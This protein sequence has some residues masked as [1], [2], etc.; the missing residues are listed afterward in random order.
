MDILFVEGWDKAIQDA[1]CDLTKA[2]RGHRYRVLLRRDAASND[3]IQRRLEQAGAICEISQ[4]NGFEAPYIA[5]LSQL[6]SG[7]VDILFGGADIPHFTFLPLLFRA[8]RVHRRTDLL[9]SFALIEAYL[10]NTERRIIMIDPTVVTDPNDDELHRMATAV[11]GMA[12]AL[13][14]KDPTIALISHATGQDRPDRNTKQSRVIRLLQR[15][16]AYDVVPEPVQLDT[17]LFRSVAE[18]KLGRRSA[19]PD[20]LVLPDISAANILYKSIEHFGGNLLRITAP[21]LWRSPVGEVGLL[22]R[23]TTKAQILRSFDTLVSMA[24][25]PRAAESGR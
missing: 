5:G 21:L 16:S 4:N 17:A 1:V 6:A 12:A 13:L 8:L 18:K 11:A 10:E 22:P 24:R 9:T 7:R 15:T 20:V 25:V 23:T 14:G 3:P 19:L 2:R